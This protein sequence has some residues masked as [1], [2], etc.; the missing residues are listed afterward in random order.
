MAV[1]VLSFEEWSE[2][3]LPRDMY[4]RGYLNGRLRL[5]CVVGNIEVVLQVLRLG[6]NVNT[7]L[8]LILVCSGA[9]APLNNARARVRIAELLLDNGV[10]PNLQD[11]SGNTALHY[12][13]FHQHTA[14]VRLLISRGANPIVLNN[15][16]QTPLR[17]ATS[18]DVF[19]N[20]EILELLHI[21]EIGF[22]KKSRKSK[23]SKK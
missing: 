18:R 11:D 9:A 20:D 2:R 7:G 23:K 12:A 5:A 17:M 10:D 8:P 13:V 19:V 21:P 22:R 16:R 14:L 4:A 6:V 3:G 1:P 15:S